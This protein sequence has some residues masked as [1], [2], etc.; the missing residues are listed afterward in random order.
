[1]DKGRRK[2]SMASRRDIIKNK[3][4]KPIHE[5]PIIVTKEDL[6]Y[7]KMYLDFYNDEYWEKYKAEKLKRYRKYQ[8]KR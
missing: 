3:K 1:M 2:G 8:T 4:I 5:L 6:E 7:E